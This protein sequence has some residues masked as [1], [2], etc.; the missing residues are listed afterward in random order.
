MLMLLVA[1]V[2]Q[3]PAPCLHAAAAAREATAGWGEYRR[4]A[5]VQ[6]ARRFAVADSLCP[7]DHA[8][9]VGL[10]FVR[11]RQGKPGAAAERFLG[12]VASDTSDAEAWYGL[13]LAR[14]PRAS[15]GRRPTR[16]ATR[17]VSPG[18]RSFVS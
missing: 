7:G 8:T 2:S 16:G 17:Y 18:A 5:I 6:A 1:L 3:V 11:L 10:G 4:G 13:G 15:V 9:Q 14:S 12:A